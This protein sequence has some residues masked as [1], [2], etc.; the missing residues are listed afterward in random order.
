MTINIPIETYKRLLE[1]LKILE[2][3]LSSLP[4]TQRAVADKI[5]AEL[6][7]TYRR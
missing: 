1:A 2:S 6:K 4:E 3:V 7:A 5:V